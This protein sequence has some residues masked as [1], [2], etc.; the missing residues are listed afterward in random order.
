MREFITA[1]CVAYAIIATVM[2]VVSVYIDAGFTSMSALF[3][4]FAIAASFAAVSVFR[5]RGK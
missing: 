3:G 4:A 1:Y 2:C 5:Q